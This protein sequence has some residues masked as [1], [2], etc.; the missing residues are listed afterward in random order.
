LRWPLYAFVNGNWVGIN[1]RLRRV[2]DRDSATTA[3]WFE[4]T[5]GPK[6]AIG[7]HLLG[8]M[9]LS[10][11]LRRPVWA[12]EWLD[13]AKVLPQDQNATEAR[14]GAVKRIL[15]CEGQWDAMTAYQLGIPALSLPN[16]ASAIDIHSLLRFVPEAAEVWLAM[17]AD[18][19][20]ERA[21]ESFYAKLGTAVKRLHLPHKDIN[22]W[23][24]AQPN[25]TAEDVLSATKPAL[26]QGRRRRSLAEM[27]DTE[28]TAP[29]LVTTTAWPALNERIKGGLYECEV[30]SLL[31]P[32]GIGKTT[33]ANEII[34]YAAL[35][36][37]KCG[38][39]QLEGDRGK[40]I[41]TLSDQISGRGKVLDADESMIAKAKDNVIFSELAGKRVSVADTI[42]EIRTMLSE[43]GCKLVVIDNWDYIT[44]DTENGQSLKVKAF[45]ELQTLVKQYRAHGIA[46]WQPK[47]VDRNAVVNSGSQKGLSVVL[48]DSDNYL[49]LNRVGMMRRIDVEKARVVEQENVS[50]VIWL[51]FEPEL[52]CMMQ[53]DSAA[54]L[55]LLER[56]EQPYF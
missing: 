56:L 29:G 15:V 25:L 34:A 44:G 52:N 4:L 32:S 27:D 22:A 18:T 42:E 13:S 55:H 35:Q 11:G 40:V 10:W 14:L 23:L 36:G 39:I 49:A 43:D 19:A 17:D 28:M 37:C 53:V 41:K 47:K 51:K 54:S 21:V 26:S 50:S 9:P 7:N 20:G 8:T 1:A 46:V 12:S 16:G 3:D 2:I 24:M 31:A 48:Q 33:I 6:T 38:V 30:T 45:A 5:G